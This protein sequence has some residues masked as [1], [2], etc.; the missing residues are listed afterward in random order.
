MKLCALLMLTACTPMSD[1]ERLDREA[2]EAEA[3]RETVRECRGVVLVRRQGGR[4]KTT[5]DTVDIDCGR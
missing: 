3:N 1:Y 2:R 5:D 4:L